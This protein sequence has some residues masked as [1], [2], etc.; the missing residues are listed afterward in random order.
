MGRLM[1]LWPYVSPS[2]VLRGSMTRSR[3]MHYERSRPRIPQGRSEEAVRRLDEAIRDPRG[4]AVPQHWAFAAMAYHGLGQHAEARR[5]L[6]RLRYREPSPD[7]IRFW[8]E[9]EIDL[10]RAEAEAVIV[11]DR[12]FPDDPFAR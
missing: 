3:P 12:A 1:R 5:W 9:M 6:E 11:Y 2:A 10:L 8:D 7:P 4:S